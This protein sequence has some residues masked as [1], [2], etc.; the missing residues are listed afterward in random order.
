[1][2]VS[3]FLFHRQAHMCHMLDSQKHD[4]IC[5]LSLSFWLT[6]PSMLISRPIHVA[7]LFHS[8]C[9][10]GIFRCIYVPRL[11]EAFICWWTLTFN[12]W[13]SSLSQALCWAVWGCNGW[14]TQVFMINAKGK[15][16]LVKQGQPGREGLSDGERRGAFPGDHHSTRAA[17]W[18]WGCM[19]ARDLI[20]CVSAR[21]FYLVLHKED[22]F[23][24][25]RWLSKCNRKKNLTSV[26]LYDS[27]HICQGLILSALLT[28]P[29][30][31]PGGTRESSREANGSSG[32]PQ[33]MSML[34]RFQGSR[35]WIQ[36]SYY[37]A[38][39]L[40]GITEKIKHF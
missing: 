22:F 37:C 3:L 2:S 6:S 12:N 9:A 27:L 29:I 26:V 36:T 23:A 21:E 4:A 38:H 30:T 15:R 34:A 24:W 1:M 16:S 10:R 19:N 8:F 18:S 13:A 7:A 40:Q 33:G 28:N 11:R 14:L 39:Q 17:R 25:G 32:S 35:F 5:C 31:R 20:R